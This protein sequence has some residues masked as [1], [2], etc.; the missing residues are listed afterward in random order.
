MKRFLYLLIIVI[1]LLAA[2]SRPYSTGANEPFTPILPTDVAGVDGNGVDGGGPGMGSPVAPGAGEAISATSVPVSVPTSIP[3]QAL[4][5]SVGDGGLASPT[6]D[7][8]K[9]LATLRTKVE[10][11]VVQRNDTLNAISARYG[12]DLSAVMAANQISDPNLIK[13]GQVLTIPT[14]DVRNRGT[15]FKVIPDSEL[16]YSP[17]S[18]GFTIQAFIASKQG[19]LAQYSETVDNLTY[20]GAKIIERIAREYSVNPRLLLAVLEYQSGWVTQSSVSDIQRD[21]PIGRVETTRKGLY[22]QMAWAADNLNRGYY[23][24][25][26]D[27]VSNWLLTDG[28]VVPIAPDINAGT[29]GVQGFFATMN[30]RAGWDKAV[31]DKGLYAVYNSLFGNPFKYS[32]EPMLPANLTQ[33]KFQLPFEVGK[34]WSFTGGPHGGWGTGSAWA[35]LD[36]GPPTEG[37]GC[38]SSDEWVVAVASGVIVKSEMGAV[39]E[40][41]DGDGDERTGWSVLYMHIGTND[42]I[43]VGSKP[44]AGDRIGH[45]SCEGGVSNG[46]HTHIARR[47]NG[48]WIPADGPLPFNLEGWISGGTGTEYYGF[49][50]KDGQVLEPWDAK[51]DTNQISR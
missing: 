9:Q 41:L 37:G 3:G 44:K 39:V 29:A 38:R 10:K 22:K 33:P 18:I 24:W 19:Y 35:A 30:N 49:L 45:P 25:R 1:T 40:D 13:V 8:P 27:A 4:P 50:K 15:G 12:V 48:E 20:S 34:E 36:F 21:Y 42:R 46:T 14:P 43:T 26:A 16:V 2:C 31:S 11:Y 28:S 17:G 32:F 7:Q 23:L 5:S 51:T 6:P 47:Y